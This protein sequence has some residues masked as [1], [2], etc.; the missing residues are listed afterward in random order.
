MLIMLIYSNN[1]KEKQRIFSNRSKE[2]GL[3][4]NAEKT[5]YVVITRDQNARHNINTLIGNKSFETV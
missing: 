1:Y 2:T 3:E 5:K 4:V